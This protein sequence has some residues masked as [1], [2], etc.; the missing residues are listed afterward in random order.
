MIKVMSCESK[1]RHFY[2]C[3]KLSAYFIDL[4]CFSFSI[5][6]NKL[7]LKCLIDYTN[8]K[9]KESMMSWDFQHYNI[10]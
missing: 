4:I 5:F 3:F 1:V 9:E 8:K 7:F 6:Y 10:C 2:E